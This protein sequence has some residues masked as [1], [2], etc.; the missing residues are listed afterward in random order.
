MA[1]AG[2]RA[3]FIMEQSNGLKNTYR[4][5]FT[6]CLLFIF[7][8]YTGKPPTYTPIVSKA[9]Y[10]QKKKKCPFGICLA[11]KQKSMEKHNNLHY[12]IP[13]KNKKIK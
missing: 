12:S 2:V 4:G 3:N 6:S 8:V 11:D 7:R 9:F 10:C 13:V 1:N 5:L